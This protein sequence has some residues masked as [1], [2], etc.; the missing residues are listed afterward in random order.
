M[1]IKAAYEQ[2]IE[3]PD[4]CDVT[5]ED[6]KVIVTGPLG[7]LEREFPEL[8]ADF[9]I[10]GNELVAYTQVSR[11]KTRAL[12][13][14]IVAHVRNMLTGVQH[15]YEYTL[16]VVYSH[17]PPTVKDGDGFVVISNFLGERGV[18]KARKI[19]DVDIKISED[20][21]V[22]SGISIEDVSQT[23]ANIQNS[24]RIRN[25]DRRVFLDGI[26]VLKKRKGTEVKSVV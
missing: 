12:V 18:R 25:K 15:G 23:A 13:G 20:E 17:F 7:T 26:Y 11:K 24:T 19:G 6:K 5:V 1:S 4:D 9:Q 22:I 3:I 2:R 21:V 16:K 8:I 10:D 14:S